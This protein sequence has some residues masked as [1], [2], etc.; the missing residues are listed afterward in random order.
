LDQ[1]FAALDA[2]SARA[3]VNALKPWENAPTRAVVIAD[4]VVH[5]ALDWQQVIELAHRG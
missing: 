4:Y 5:P 3:L 2:T 1:P